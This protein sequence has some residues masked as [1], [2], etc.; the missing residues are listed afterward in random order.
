MR[1]LSAIFRTDRIFWKAEGEV[2]D[3]GDYFLIRTPTNPT[4]YFGN[5]LFFDHPPGK[6]DFEHWNRLFKRE[7]KDD[8]EVKHV[9]FAWDMADDA[10]GVISPFDKGGFDI[11]NNISLL[12][13]EVVPPPKLNEEIVVRRIVTDDEWDIVF[14]SKLRLRDARFKL[15][16]Y[17]PFK[18]KWLDV[19]RRLA[20]QGLGS[21]YGAFLDDRLVGDLGLFR[22]GDLGRFQDVAT[23]TEFRRRGICGTL[24]YNVSK[25]ALKDG[26]K[27][28][29]MV[30]DEN[31]HAAGIYESVGFKPI[32]K[33]ASACRFPD[34]A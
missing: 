18:K 23:E 11:Q 14:D 7:F 34:K 2:I 12:A 32:E 17:A 5:L 19:R 30:A 25:Q 31:Y 21:W 29:V 26:I 1:K 9:V 27:T 22:D 24:V 33:H 28:L 4:Y 3:R 8:N 20:E 16:T 6:G 10:V 13:T 15:S